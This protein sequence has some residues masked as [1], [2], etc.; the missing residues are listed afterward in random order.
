MPSEVKPTLVARVEDK[1][2]CIIPCKK[3]ENKV[4]S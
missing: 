4:K 3:K 1:F 2:I